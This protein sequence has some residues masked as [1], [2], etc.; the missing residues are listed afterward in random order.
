[1]GVQT[2]LNAI[3]ECS[4]PAGIMEQ[5]TTYMN[6]LGRAYGYW[7]VGDQ[8]ILNTGLGALTYQSTVP[9][10]SYDQTHLLIGKTW[11]LVAYDDN[12]STPGTQE[13][14]TVFNSNG[15]LTGYTGCNSFE[16]N[17]T[18]SIQAITIDALNS[19]K[20]AC[21]SAELDAQEKAIFAILGS[22][23]SYQVSSSAMQVI[24][25]EG[26]LTYSLTPLHRTEEVYPPTATFSMPSEA[27]TDQVV[28]FD[29][30]ASTGQVPLVSYQWTF[31]D[32]W[33]GTGA[34]IEHVYTDPG[35][36]QVSLVVTDERGA[37]DTEIQNIVIA[38]YV[39]PTPPPTQ[40]PPTPTPPAPPT[41]PPPPPPRATPNPPPP[42][43]PRN[44]GE[45]KS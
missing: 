2:T 32:G 13:P 14:F 42:P 5:E 22:A 20:A 30:S 34:V 24:G 8:F 27:S 15:T 31:G 26:V 29:G 40:V 7:V 36:Y 25:D 16:G 41:P 1:M 44:P 12:Y 21:P 18:T 11:Y 37:N 9:A 17:Y 35:T 45:P 10:E 38:A 39:E 19:T 33:T 23:L 6:M 28:R 43:P 4:T 3:Q